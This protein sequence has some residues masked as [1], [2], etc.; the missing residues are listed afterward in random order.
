MYAATEVVKM[1]GGTTGVLGG[2]S[3]C[4][5]RGGGGASKVVAEVT[6]AVAFA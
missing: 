3:G 6:V 2:A 1:K 4:A 5:S